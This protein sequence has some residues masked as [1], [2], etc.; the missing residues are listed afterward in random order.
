VKARAFSEKLRVRRFLEKERLHAGMRDEPPNHQRAVRLGNHSGFG[1]IRV[2]TGLQVL[3]D[4]GPK[5]SFERSQ[6]CQEL[7][8]VKASRLPSRVLV[9]ELREIFLPI[10]HF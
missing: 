7:W 3:G 5:L 10:E 1:I 6:R 8:T 9:R 2:D 4:I